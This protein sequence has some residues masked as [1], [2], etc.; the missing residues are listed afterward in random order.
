MDQGGKEQK[1]DPILLAKSPFGRWYYI[2][3]EMKGLPIGMFH[4]PLCGEMVIAG[5]PHIDYDNEEKGERED[6]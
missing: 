3:E 4:C 2:L 1:K 6:A 5:Q